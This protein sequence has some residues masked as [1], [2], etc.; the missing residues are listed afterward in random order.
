VT[1][2]ILLW[3]EIARRKL[4]VRRRTVAADAATAAGDV[5]PAAYVTTSLATAAAA[6]NT[7]PLPSARASS[8]HQRMPFNN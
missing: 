3:R 2:K 6:V 8:Q 1:V 4:Y 7:R 5:R